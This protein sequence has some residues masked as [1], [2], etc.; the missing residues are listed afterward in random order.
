M[1]LFHGHS[2]FSRPAALVLQGR[3]RQKNGMRRIYRV[4]GAVLVAN[5]LSDSVFLTA[6]GGGYSCYSA[7]EETEFQRAEEAWPRT[8]SWR[9]TEPGFK[10]WSS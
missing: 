1:Q 8:H 6:L 9:V 3:G 4:S 2:K 7:A 10:S 5:A